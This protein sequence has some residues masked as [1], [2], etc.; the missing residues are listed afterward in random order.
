[1]AESATTDD[2]AGP[3]SAASESDKAAASEKLKIAQAELLAEQKKH[4]PDAKDEICVTA[5]GDVEEVVKSGVKMLKEGA[6][7]SVVVRGSGKLV[8]KAVDTANAISRDCPGAVIDAHT[9]GF[10]MP[11]EREDYPG[12]RLVSFISI[13]LKA[14]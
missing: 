10:E 1:M 11:S 13:M 7:K 12:K 5:D 6:T 8:G 9:G 2:I 4:F 3:R 14:K